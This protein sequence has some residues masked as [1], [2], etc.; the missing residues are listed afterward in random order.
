[1]IYNLGDKIKTLTGIIMALFL[2]MTLFSCSP[3]QL[4]ET[5]LR[6]FITN[7]LKA[8]EPKLKALN[9]ADWNANATGEKKFYDE[10]AALELEVN[11]IRSNKTD[12]AFLKDLKSKGTIKDTLLARQLVVLFNQYA[13]NQIDTLLMK[14]IVEKQAEIAAKFNN[15]RGKI[16]GKEINDNQ[17]SDILSKD[18]N[19]SKRKLAWEASKQ[20]GKE[21]APLV[22]ELVKL[23]NQA[24]KQLGYENYYVM[25][26][27]TDEQDAAEVLSVFD[28]LKIL[29]DEPFKKLKNGLDEFLSKRFKIKSTEMMPWH[30]ANPFFQEVSELGEVDLDKYFKGK[31]IEELSK[32][33]YGG[34]NLPVEDILKNS[35]LYP[36][37][38]KY[39]HAFCNDIDRLG[40]VRI[41]C[42]IADNQYWTNTMLHELGHAVYSKNV[43]RDLPYLLR[44]ESHT[45]LTEA[46]AILMGRQASNVDW[47]EAMVGINPKE[48]K[49]LQK[50]L[51]DNSRLTEILFSRW[52]QVMVRFERG[53][54]QNPDQDLNKLWWDL[55]EEYQLVK[56]PENRNEPDWAAKIHLA[57]YP[58]YYHNYMLGS[59]A[60][61]Q[62]L[63][64][65]ERD[66]LKMTG[67]SEI[68]FA[69]RPDVGKFFKD[70]IFSSGA[71]YQWNKLLRYATG[72]G[73][74]PKYFAEE[75]VKK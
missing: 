9:L 72:E 49:A 73:L 8:V 41:M 18:L 48:K 34:I 67:F 28:D 38:K 36:R 75:F 66:G 24:A 71:K 74:T 53:L 63:N 57:Q 31:N 62:I 26:L 61:S 6:E 16:D 4:D 65:L 23:R 60:A 40:D 3:Q 10:R 11:T 70:K 14:Q 46:I 29:T 64:A 20:V 7:H 25:S 17:I 55:V 12:F 43:N 2:S 21:V 35:D 32:N 15:F 51:A 68:S 37:D 59:M 19:S 50:S 42:S 13:K 22:I 1:M 39:Q 52:A 33:F 5:K 69:A 30:Y 27:A 54:Y 45:F 44:S 58:C 47:I 56:R